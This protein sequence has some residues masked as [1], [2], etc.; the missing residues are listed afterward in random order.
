MQ[1]RAA[2]L[3]SLL[4]CTRGLPYQQITNI[5][6]NPL[7]NPP[8][9][10]VNGVPLPIPGSLFGGGPPIKLYITVSTIK[11]NPIDAL[12][13]NFFCRHVR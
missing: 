7:I 9:S 2:L 6:L 8:Q 3:A 5:T 4:A 10:I 1:V 12:S 13:G 11:M